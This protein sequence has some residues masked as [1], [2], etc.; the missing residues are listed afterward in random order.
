MID[1]HRLKKV[2]I[3]AVSRR[4]ALVVTLGFLFLPARETVHSQSFRGEVAE[5]IEITDGTLRH[6]ELEPGQVVLLAFAAQ[7]PYVEAIQLRVV[8]PQGTSLV[9]GAFSLNVHAGVDPATEMTSGFVTIAGQALGTVPA[10]ASRPYLV[11]V[12]TPYAAGR[13]IA[14]I[15]QTFRAAD[16]QLGLMAIQIAPAMKGISSDME[17]LVL[18]LEITPLRSVIGGIQ[19]QL[20]GDLDV[21]SRA[22][23][24]LRITLDDTVVPEGSYIFREPGIYHLE[25]R[26]GDY[27][28][29]RENVGIDAARTTRILLEARVP[30]AFLGIQVPSVAE[31]FLSGERIEHTAG[32]ILEYPPGTYIMLIRMGDFVISRRVTFRANRE[33]QIGLDLDIMITE[34]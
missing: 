18:S 19:I 12:N 33:Y 16:P 8:A 20:T 24:E 3:R 5:T 10:E 2:Q 7:Y 21:Q 4:I 9:P 31:V 23:E 22:R 17:G 27:L 1:Q 34:N 13:E 29:H 30:R 28:H 14:L 6:A 11:P 32:S 26:A 15:G 25:A